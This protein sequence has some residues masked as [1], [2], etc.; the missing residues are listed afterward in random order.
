MKSKLLFATFGMALLSGCVGERLDKR[1]APDIP[2]T[3]YSKNNGDVCIYPSPKE[4]EKQDT[5]YISSDV[6]EKLIEVASQDL[7]KGIC[8]SQ[9]DYR[10]Q[11]NHAYS[12]RLN[13][14]PIEKR[15]NLQDV[16]GR[17]FVAH[18]KVKM[19]KGTYDIENVVQERVPIE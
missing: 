1:Y 14:V 19:L 13:F 7:K 9:H 2:I 3:A 17:A 10:F 4:N 6:G 16:Y 11:E 15:Q 18:F 8:I 5:V 12:L